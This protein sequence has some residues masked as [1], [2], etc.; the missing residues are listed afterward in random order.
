MGKLR[1]VVSFKLIGCWILISCGFKVAA[2]DCGQP[3]FCDRL[4]WSPQGR[5]PAQASPAMTNPSHIIVHHSGDNL[6]WPVGTDFK[7]VVQ[8]YWDE[9]VNTNGW[10]DIGYNWLIDRNGVIYEGRGDGIRGAHFSCMNQATT[11]ICLIGNFEL[12]TPT[13][14][15]TN[16]L[17]DLIAWEATDKN[18]EVLSGSQHPSSQLDLFHISGHRDGNSSPA[19][20]SCASGTV[21]PGENLY[22]LL[23]SVRIDVGNYQCYNGNPNL[24]DCDNAISLS[25]GILYTGEASSDTSSVFSYAC[26]NWTET[27]PERVHII[28]PT[29]DGPL[30][31]ELFGFTGDLDVYILGSC[32]PSD[33]LGTVSSSSAMYNEAKAGQSYRIVVDSDDG[34][35]SSYQLLVTCSSPVA[36][37]DIELE[38]LIKLYPN[39]GHDFL[40]YQ[41]PAD[42]KLEKIAI[43]N[44]FGQVV[45]TANPGVHID[46]SQLPTGTYIVRFTDQF[47]RKTNLKWVKNK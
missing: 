47:Q 27:G 4:C 38:P 45:K 29:T 20:Q 8:A 23:S 10:A 3:N 9:H 39:P 7:L 11:G 1:Q 24:L 43:F 30:T 42:I 33:C 31:A 2:Q 18:I 14:T 5:H 35:S 12:E 15:A 34:S 36:T 40:Y 16:K 25:C 13:A 32:D 46:A 28:T 37:E 26:N 6:V 17:K 19:P 41:I 21:C 44:S 22:N